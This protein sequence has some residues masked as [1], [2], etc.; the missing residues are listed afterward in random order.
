[1]GSYTL[2]DVTQSGRSSGWWRTVW[3]TL[4][5]A[6]VIVLSGI[7][8]F[9]SIARSALPELDGPVSAAGLSAPVSVTRGTHGVPTIEAA[10]LDDLFFAQGYVTAQDRLFQMDL[11]RRAAA[12][13]LSEVVGAAALEHDRQQRILGIR[14]AAEKGMA[15]ASPEDLRQFDDYAQG[16]NAYIESH[17]DKLPLEFRVLRYTPRPWSAEDCMLVADQMVQTL[18]A[19]PHAAI[20]REKILAKL[21]P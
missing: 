9:L 4:I 8:W 20:T 1:M 13:E 2:T 5:A 17:R 19:S 6:V 15:A 18:S 12:G 16:V 10:N 14:A 7:A 21:W 11:L 3:L